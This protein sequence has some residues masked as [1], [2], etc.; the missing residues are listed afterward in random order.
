MIALHSTDIEH[1]A[2]LGLRQ[3]DIERQ[4]ALLKRGAHP[5]HLVRPATVNDGIIQLTSSE[6]DGLVTLFE[7]H[8]PDLDL[9]KFVPASGA[10]TRMFKDLRAYQQ[11]GERSPAIDHFFDNVQR[12]AFWQPEYSEWDE[13]ELMAALLSSRGIGLAHRPKGSVPFHRYEDKV[14]TAF[15]EQL[16]EA[17]TY[18]Q[19]REGV[20]IHFT[21]PHQRQKETREEISESARRIASDIDIST[22]VQPPETDTVCLDPQG[23]LMRE[24]DGRLLLRPGGHGSLL[25][26]LDRISADIVFVKNIDNV[27]VEHK[28]ADTVKYKKALGGLL[29][30]IRQE[31]RDLLGQVRRGEVSQEQFSAFMKRL[32]T[33]LGM[34][35]DDAEKE[36]L[37]LRPFRICG[38]VRNEGEPGGGP[39]WTRDSAGQISLQIVESAQMDLS[40]AGQST[41]ASSATHFNPVDLVCATKD[42][43]EKEI[44]LMS[45]RDMHT[46]FVT[47][48]SVEGRES[49]ILEWPGLWNGAMAHWNTVFVEVPLTTFNPVKTVNDLLRSAHQS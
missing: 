43:D 6:L 20:R 38:M 37:L 9:L 21:V 28:N 13:E 3:T 5:A 46:A 18:C 32:G 29:I 7:R 42:L 35:V 17:R 19:G 4:V 30:S 26:E 14:R 12:F 22:G 23:R 48:K 2:T 16:H 36:D 47:Q 10:A 34:P 33:D 11:G 31:A 24:E 27:C 49:T 15:D 39:F 44:D 1:L 41:I 40:D 8:A 25:A 45:Y